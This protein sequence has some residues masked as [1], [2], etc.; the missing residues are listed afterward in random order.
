[1]A[2]AVADNGTFTR[3]H[4]DLPTMEVVEASSVTVSYQSGGSVVGTYSEEVS[5]DS[6]FR[7]YVKKSFGFPDLPSA[8]PGV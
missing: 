6:C 4:G 7:F 3:Q 5:E 1:M 2:A 8:L